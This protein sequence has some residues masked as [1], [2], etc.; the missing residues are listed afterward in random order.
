VASVPLVLFTLFG[1]LALLAGGSIFSVAKSA[2]HEIEAFILL[3]IG[4][5][6]LVGAAL[7][8]ALRTVVEAVYA[9]KD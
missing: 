3:L 8:D 1:V 9:D 5:V 6:F 2:V 7:L 4:A